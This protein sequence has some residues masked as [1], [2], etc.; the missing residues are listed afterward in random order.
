MPPVPRGIFSMWLE[1]R[2]LP[3]LDEATLRKAASFVPMLSS[4]WQS[5]QHPDTLP[6]DPNAGKFRF[7]GKFTANPKVAGSWT[8]VAQVA[9]PADFD[10]QAKPNPGR[11]PFQKINFKEDGT[12]DTARWI[13][14]GA[15]LIDL[16]QD[17]ALKIAPQSIG[18]TDYLFIESGGFSP[19]KPAGW[20]SP[21]MVLKRN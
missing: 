16:E 14:S 15:T 4:D 21:L 5:L 7:D 18:G 9:K 10:P 11:S 3:P 6:E 1:E 19:K 2:K 13:W 8:A 17:T 12:T 20:T